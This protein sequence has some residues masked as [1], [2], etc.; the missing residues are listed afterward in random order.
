[1]EEINMQ[2]SKPMTLNYLGFQ[3]FEFTRRAH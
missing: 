3:S 2:T 1:M